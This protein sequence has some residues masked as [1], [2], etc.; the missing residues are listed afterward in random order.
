MS[1]K[2]ERTAVKLKKLNSLSFRIKVA[3]AE[4]NEIFDFT[5]S[6]N[7]V[8]NRPFSLDSGVKAI[9][10]QYIMYNSRQLM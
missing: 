9:D 4:E 8:E 3:H 6:P 7:W 1:A 2:I 10:R 5:A